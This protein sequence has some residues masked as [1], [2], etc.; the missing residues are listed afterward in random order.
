MLLL[1]AHL[2]AGQVGVFQ[3][4]VVL[5]FE[6]LGYRTFYGLATLKLQGEPGGGA[7]QT[8]HDQEAGSEHQSHGLLADIP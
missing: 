6:V 3:L 8:S 7:G 2:Q 1:L 5:L 4:Q